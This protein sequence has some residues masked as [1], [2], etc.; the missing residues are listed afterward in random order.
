MQTVCSKN[1]YIKRSL[2]KVFNNLDIIIRDSK[3]QRYQFLLADNVYQ[4]HIFNAN[5][6]FCKNCYFLPPDTLKHLC[7][8]VGKN[9]R[10]PK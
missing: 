5:T 2:E 6:K 1:R 8:T 10:F 9:V 4:G 3:L 7:I